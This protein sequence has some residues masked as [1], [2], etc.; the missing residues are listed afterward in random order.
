MREPQV[1]D[2]WED[3][4]G[5]YWTVEPG[6]EQIEWSWFPGWFSSGTGVPAQFDP[7]VDWKQWRGSTV[8]VLAWDGHWTT[9]GEFTRRAAANGW[10]L[11]DKQRRTVNTA[12]TMKQHNALAAIV[13]GAT[14][15]RG[16]T[17]EVLRLTY[18]Q[19]HTPPPRKPPPRTP[20]P[21]AAAMAA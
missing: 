2:S 4:R 12:V 10:R 16:V 6:E 15:E 20:P 21:A 13:W 5:R 7:Q 9:V 14:Y 8:A 17:Y 19:A 1:I 18:F 3:D 11:T